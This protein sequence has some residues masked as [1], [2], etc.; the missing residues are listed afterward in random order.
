MNLNELSWV[1]EA[2]GSPHEY[3]VQY[4]ADRDR[5]FHYTDLGALGSIATNHD[6]WLTDSRFSNDSDEM[7]HG[8]GVVKRTIA[9]RQ[10]RPGTSE[11]ERSFLEAVAERVE[12]AA[13]RSVF[14]SCFCLDDDLLGQWRGYSQGG[15]GVSIA[16]RTDGFWAISGPDGQPNEV[17]LMYLWRVFYGAE[18]QTR[19]VDDCLDHVWQGG[20][21]GDEQVELAVDA[22]R[23]FIPTF[24]NEAFSDE[25]EARLVF[26]PTDACPVPPRFRMSRGMLVPYFS[27]QNLAAAAGNESWRLPIAAVTIGPSALQREHELSARLL[28]AATGYQEVPV[29]RSPTPFRG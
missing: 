21:S 9:E 16:L 22:L 24:K 15:A 28:L 25:K 2:L 6:L 5:V 29:G 13:E 23:F 10:S 12:H 19:I 18:K 4:M 7:Q 27:L 26:A 20:L 3:F 17:G 1:L 11:E 8:F 14:I